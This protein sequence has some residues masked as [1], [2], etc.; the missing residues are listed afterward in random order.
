MIPMIWLIDIWLINHWFMDNW[1][2]WRMEVKSA[3]EVRVEEARKDAEMVW[4]PGMNPGLAVG[5]L[6]GVGFYF[7]VV[8]LL[9]LASQTFT[10]V[11]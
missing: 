2:G 9:P 6:A 7:M 3:Q 1:P 4:T 10:L 8:W 11:K 5:V